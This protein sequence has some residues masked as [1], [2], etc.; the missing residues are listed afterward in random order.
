MRMVVAAKLGGMRIAPKFLRRTAQSCE[1]P[2]YRECRMLHLSEKR[3]GGPIGGL[4]VARAN[5]QFQVK[6]DENDKA[7]KVS[8]YQAS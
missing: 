3:I 6:R 8:K 7:T 1:M 4:I 5:R 2:A